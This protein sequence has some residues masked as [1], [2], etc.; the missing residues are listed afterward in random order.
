MQRRDPNTIDL[1]QQKLRLAS[2]LLFWPA[3]ECGQ[4]VYRIEIPSQHRF[5][6][7][8]YEEYIFI[9]LLDG[10]TTIPQ[11]CGLAAAKLGPQAPTASQATSIARWLLKNE[12]ATL[13]A[14]PQPNRDRPRKANPRVTPGW[15]Q[16]LNPFWIKVP[17]PHSAHWT[18]LCAAPLQIFFGKRLAVLGLLFICI[19]AVVLAS[20]WTEFSSQTNNVFH[21]SNWLWLLLTWLGLKFTHE[22]GHAAACQRV[23]GSVRQAGLVFILFAP[24]AYVDV[25]SCWR[26]NSRWARILV[27]AAGMYVE[28]IVA[29]VAI[30][31]WALT[32]APQIKLWMQNLVFA[33]GFSTLLFNANVL[34]R[35]DGYFMLA[36]WIEVPNLYTEAS[37]SVR[38]LAGQLILGQK[39]AGNGLTGWRKH[40]VAVYGLAAC[41]WRVAI[42]VSLA[43]A[44]STMFAG[45]GIVIAAVGIG[46]WIGQPAL[47]LTRLAMDLKNQDPNRFVRAGLI[48]VCLICICITTICFIPIPSS[49]TSPAIVQYKPDTMV[50]SRA[51]GFIHDV[52]VHD[53][54]IVQADQ[55]LVLLENRELTNQLELLQRTRQQNEIRLRIAIDKHDAHAKQILTENQKAVHEQLA[56]LQLQVDNL[57]VRAPRDGTVVA[58][59]LNCKLGQ[60]VKEGELLLVVASPASKELIAAIDQQQIEA[61]RSQVGNTIHIR[62]VSNRLVTGTLQRIEPRASHQLI[63]PALAATAGGTL[64]VQSSEDGN[65]PQ[66]LEPHFLAHIGLTNDQAG[67]FLAGIRA[68]VSFGSRSAT[69]LERVQSE[70]REL[71]NTA[72]AY[73]TN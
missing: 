63:D 8:G 65:E 22:L 43:I 67:S 13:A 41:V 46:C 73:Q 68:E 59:N 38:N 29:A 44:A 35:F 19:A 25:S 71:L 3:R 12:L 21:P 51:S 64:A 4:P 52:L 61:A 14:E 20:R 60:Y 18:S 26:L 16:R 62:T 69:L 23:G 42:C 7:V 72:Q 30:M 45:A 27:S 49:T 15:L 24:I 6:R 54:S 33:A 66:L 11:A 2:D 32:D 1:T 70:I 17:L 10:A 50:R 39:R 36:D 47:Q 57:Q 58:R 9:S 31:V 55:P 48:S 28:L 34:M 5:F 53:G 56:Q 40:F 37:S